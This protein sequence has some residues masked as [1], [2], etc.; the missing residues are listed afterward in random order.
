M[1]FCNLFPMDRAKKMAIDTH[2]KREKK[3]SP[4]VYKNENKTSLPVKA[5]LQ[6]SVVM[7]LL[8]TPT[9]PKLYSMA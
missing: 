1:P 4:I 2:K 7:P 3:L 8:K 9:M 5:A 6:Y